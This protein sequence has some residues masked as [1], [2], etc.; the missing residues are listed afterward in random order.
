MGKNGKNRKKWP[1]RGIKNRRFENVKRYNQFV[2]IFYSYWHLRKHSH[3]FSNVKFPKAISMTLKT[4]A[5]CPKNTKIKQCF[6]KKVMWYPILKLQLNRILFLYKISPRAIF[7][8]FKCQ[9]LHPK[10]GATNDFVHILG[11]RKYLC[12][13]FCKYFNYFDC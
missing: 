8:W 11:K 6:T 10:G 2:D 4:G 13:S 9:I 12:A 5:G 7:H 3:D 1:P